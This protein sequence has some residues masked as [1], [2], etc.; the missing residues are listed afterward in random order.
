MLQ[1]TDSAREK[2]KEVQE[3]QKGK[4]CVFPWTEWVEAG[5]AWGWRWKSQRR[6]KNRCQV[7]GIDVL[8]AGVKRGL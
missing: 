3:Q 8:M 5:P 6:M 7:N 1:I 4:R 2:I